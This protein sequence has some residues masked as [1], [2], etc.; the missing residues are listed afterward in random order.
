MKQELTAQ[1]LNDE[2]LAYS[3]FDVC[4]LLGI[5]PA[6][7]Y[8]ILARGDL[9][10][11]RMVGRTLILRSDLLQFLSSLPPRQARGCGHA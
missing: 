8:R 10:S 2:R 1:P 6:T 3:V 7:L 5:A 4:R 9:P 11:R